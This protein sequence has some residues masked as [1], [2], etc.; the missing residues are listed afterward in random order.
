M[1]QQLSTAK[2]SKIGTA[3]TKLGG[4]FASVGLELQHGSPQHATIRLDDLIRKAERILAQ[5]TIE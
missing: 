1:A 5:L 3:L 2:K 4:E